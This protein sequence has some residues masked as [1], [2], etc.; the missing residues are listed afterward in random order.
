MNNA[1]GKQIYQPILTGG[2][3]EQNLRMQGQ[4]YDEESGLHYNLF[5]YYDPDSG[6]FTQLDPIGLAGG[7]NLYQYA[8]NALGWVDPLGLSRKC[9]LQNKYKEIDKQNLPGW[10]KDSFK[11]GEYKTVVTTEDITLYRVFGGY[12]KI[13]GSFVSSSPALNRIQS[14]IDSALLPE[15]KNTRQFEAVIKVPKGT[16]LQVGKV[17]KQTMLS[18]SILEGGT[19]QVLLPQGYP[20]SWIIDVRFL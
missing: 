1:W 4:Y 2:R 14:K 11:N 8:P 19:D 9:S 16:T 13:D 17:E 12:A 10:I 18:G 15:W 5:R 7:I 20:L 6:R 3:V